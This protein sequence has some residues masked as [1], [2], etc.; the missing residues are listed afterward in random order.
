MTIFNKNGI[1][2][3]VNENTGTSFKLFIYPNPADKQLFLSTAN[4]N[5]KGV[6]TVYN[7]QGQK[8]INKK[9][10]GNKLDISSLIPGVY[11]LTATVDNNL[12]R[13]KFIKK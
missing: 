4:G 6:I 3:S 12:Q 2:W 5:V 8:V 13:I 10:N 7:L 11:I 1:I 9:Y